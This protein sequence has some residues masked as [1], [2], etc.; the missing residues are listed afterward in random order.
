MIHVIFD[1]S[2][3]FRRDASG[4]LAILEIVMSNFIDDL[5]D[6]LVHLSLFESRRAFGRTL[7]ITHVLLPLRCIESIN[8]PYV[9]LS[10]TSVKLPEGPVSPNFS[11]PV[12]RSEPHSRHGKIDQP[13]PLV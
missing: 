4:G 5:S 1:N 8:P 6:D 7:T 11:R 2:L 12:R 13:V 10:T 9:I 3:Y